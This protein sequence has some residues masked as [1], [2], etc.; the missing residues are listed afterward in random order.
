MMAI[1]TAVSCSESLLL[2]LADDEYA[3]EIRDSIKPV[4]LENS[5]LFTLFRLAVDDE[6]AMAVV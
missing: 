5:S 3:R 6:A 2:E 4:V 1:S